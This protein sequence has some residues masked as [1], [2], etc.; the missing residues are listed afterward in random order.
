MRG[1]AQH[2]VDRGSR[3]DHLSF[4][5]RCLLAGSF[6]MSTKEGAAQNAPTLRSFGPQNYFRHD[7]V[8]YGYD[9]YLK[10]IVRRARQRDFGAQGA[11]LRFDG[12]DRLADFRM[13][14]DLLERHA[15]RPGSVRRESVVLEHGHRIN[16]IRFELGNGFPVIALFGY[17]SGTPRRSVLLLHGI[18]STPERSMGIGDPDYMQHLGKRL[19]SA[20]F[21]VACPFFPHAGNL[22]SV[23]AMSALMAASGLA[24]HETVVSVALACLDLLADHE[25]GKPSIERPGCYGV[26]MGALLG[27]HASILD[28]RIGSLVCSGYLRDDR[29]LLDTDLMDEMVNRGEIYPTLHSRLA[30]H[31][32]LVETVALYCPRPLFIEVGK[33]DPMSSESMG[34]AE[35]LERIRRLYR[36]RGAGSR[37]RA[38]IFDGGHEAHGRAAIPWLGS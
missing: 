1:W 13:A 37:L 11:A 6:A 25:A 22:S 7:F 38:S 10:Q 27:L 19:V 28:D 2:S 9:Q 4:L 20:R 3:R 33:H 16:R 26:S 24:F 12:D 36:S 35:S 30:W 14:F 8:R 23:S 18:G 31:Y 34:R 32:G 21:A 29:L 5:G 17:P 15:I